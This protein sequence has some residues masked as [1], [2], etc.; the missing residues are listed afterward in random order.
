[1]VILPQQ[2]AIPFAYQVQVDVNRFD[3][4]SSGRAILD[5]RWYVLADDT[6]KVTASG[7]STITEPASD[8]GDYAEVAAADESGTRRDERG[9]RRRDPRQA[10]KVTAPQRRRPQAEE[11]GWPR[12]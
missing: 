2:R 4:D 6:E 12:M 3:V 7:R 9:D 8:P 1:M 5:A 11:T 10:P